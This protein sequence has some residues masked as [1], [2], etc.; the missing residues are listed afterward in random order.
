MSYTIFRVFHDS[1][2][3]KVLQRLVLKVAEG[4]NMELPADNRCA[5]SCVVCQL[6][7][8]HGARVG[9]VLVLALGPVLSAMAGDV[10]RQFEA[11][12]DTELVEGATE[13]VLN[14]LLRGADD[15]A[16]FA[17]GHSLPH[18]DRN[19]NLLDSQSFTG[20]HDCDSSFPNIAM[21]SFTRLRPSR[22][23]VRKNRVRKCCFTVRGLILS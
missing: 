13:V 19:L 18:Q 23:P 14:H 4:S 15:P 16:D 22:I 9:N 5:R 2:L 3:R 11:A 20:R 6:V 10:H 1:S 17:I 12:P 7:R 8:A 21:A